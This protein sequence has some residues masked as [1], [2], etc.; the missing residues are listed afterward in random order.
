MS[1][2]LAD[3]DVQRADAPG[4]GLDVAMALEAVLGTAPSLLSVP[5]GFTPQARD[6]QCPGSDPAEIPQTTDQLGELLSFTYDLTATQAGQL[7]IPVV[8]SVGAAT[9]GA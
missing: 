8:G 4:V 7:N 3:V 9:A 6:G 5:E 1:D 2:V